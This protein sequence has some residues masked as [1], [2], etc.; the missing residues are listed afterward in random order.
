MSYFA[1]ELLSIL[2]NIL[3]NAKSQNKYVRYTMGVFSAVALITGLQKLRMTLYRK[4]RSLSN[5]PVGYPLLGSGMQFT[6]NLVPFLGKLSTYG[7]FSHFV[8]FGQDTVIINDYKLARAIYSD[9]RLL[10]RPQ[11][12][13]KFPNLLQ[14][15]ALT[16]GKEWVEGRKLSFSSLAKLLNKPFIEKLLKKVFEEHTFVTLDKI[17]DG[18]LWFPSLSCRHIAFNTIFGAV[19]GKTIARD[20]ELFEKLNTTTSK[21][22]NSL[23][24]SLVL[25]QFLHFVVSQT[26]EA[27][28][29]T[30]ISL[31]KPIVEEEINNYDSSNMETWLSYMLHEMSRANN[32]NNNENNTNPDKLNITEK[33]MKRIYGE[34][35]TLVSAGVET[36]GFV[37][38]YGV[39][40]LAK[41]PKYQQMLYDELI[42]KFEN[43]EFQMSKLNECPILRAFVN[44]ALRDAAPAGTGGSRAPIFDYSIDITK[45]NITE[46]YAD[47]IGKKCFIPK[48]TLLVFNYPHFANAEVKNFNIENYLKYDEV[49][50]TY[51]YESRLPNV[52]PFSVG[53]RNCPGENIA[54]AELI[55]FF[56]QLV[57][58]YQIKSPVKEE[59]LVIKLNASPVMIIEPKIGVKV[60]RR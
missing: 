42:K 29:N 32:E 16:N 1:S 34:I 18:E 24:I 8:V 54:M 4:S 25:P 33:D 46:E 10:T 51:K 2:K 53:K 12:N 55:I 14:L 56:A 38:E 60:E 26:T 39:L 23:G 7:P 19:C 9:D 52:F 36:T 44:E 48:N 11:M 15:T 17:R 13:E 3:K 49:N 21:W 37:M 58:N 45:D 57:L 5:G 6:T 22:F 43:K 28:Q 20:D 35:I 50:K 40:M 31:L 41:Y 27:Y 30:L 47:F 59:E